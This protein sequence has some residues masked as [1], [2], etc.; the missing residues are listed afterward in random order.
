MAIT[1]TG[2]ALRFA[3]GYANSGTVSSTITVPADAEIVL[4]G[5]V[6]YA[7]VANVFSA[8]GMTFTKGGS[9][10]AM[11]SAVTGSTGADNNTGLQQAALFY[12]V[13]PDTGTNKTLTWD[14]VGTAGLTLDA[15]VSVIF[16]KG[17]DTAS[18]VRDAKGAQAANTP[19]TTPTLTASS[20]DLIVAWAGMYVTAEGTI[21][22]WSNLTEI[23]ELT[24]T[25][26]SDG[27]WAS[28]SPTGNTTVAASTD[29]NVDDGGIVGIV[30]KPSAGGGAP[31][32][33]LIVNRQLTAAMRRSGFY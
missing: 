27:A 5:V 14:W 9:G 13:L 23:T 8:G 30:L 22:S 7:G 17:I 10:T 3:P 16:F 24:F 18:A 4:V 28:G 2:T 15:I 32:P 20:G 12:Q 6:G 26:N 31:A 11:T 33:K 29:T 19:F 1:Q 25:N 21:N